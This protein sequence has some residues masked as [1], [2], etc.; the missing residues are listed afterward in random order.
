[1]LTASIK[2]HINL[3][4]KYPAS[5]SASDGLK[6]GDVI[7]NHPDCCMIVTEENIDRVSDDSDHWVVIANVGEGYVYTLLQKES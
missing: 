1:M 4:V 3:K 7:C 2:N 5:T 6:V